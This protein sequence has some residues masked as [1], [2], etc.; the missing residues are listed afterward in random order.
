MITD[1]QIKL[2]MRTAL[3]LK[4]KGYEKLAIAVVQVTIVEKMDD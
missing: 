2:L 1:D 4:D 3:I